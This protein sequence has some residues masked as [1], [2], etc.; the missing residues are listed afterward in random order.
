MIPIAIIIVLS[1]LVVSA[2]ASYAVYTKNK[3][4]IC[5]KYAK[6]SGSTFTCPNGFTKTSTGC[7]CPNGYVTMSGDTPVCNTCPSNAKC[8]DT[9][10]TCGSGFIKGETSCVCPVNNYIKG[11]GST[12]KCDPCP[13]NALCHGTNSFDC[14]NNFIKSE[15]GCECQGGYITGSGNRVTCNECPDNSTCSNSGFIC[16]NGFTSNGSACICPPSKYTTAN[17]L[18]TNCPTNAI[19]N[20]GTGYTCPPG[21]IDLGNGLGCSCGPNKTIMGSGPTL[22]CLTCMDTSAVTCKADG[23]FTC[24]SPY[25]LTNRECLCYSG[26]GYIDSNGTCS[27]CPN[28]AICNGTGYNC[29][30]YGFTDVNGT[31]MCPSGY[32]SF[33]GNNYFCRTPCPTNANCASTYGQYGPRGYACNNNYTLMSDGSCLC[34][35]GTGYIN[36]SGA[37]VPCPP[38]AKC[39]GVNSDC[40]YY[41]FTKQNGACVCN[42]DYISFDGT[43]YHCNGPCPEHASC[44]NTY[45]DNPTGYTC[46][47]GFTNI[48]NDCICNGYITPLLDMPSVGS[49]IAGVIGSTCDT[50]PPRAD[51]T[52]N[53]LKC[54]NGFVRGTTNVRDPTTG[55]M[56]STYSC[57][58]TGYITGTGSNQKCNPCPKYGICGKNS[59]TFT[60]TGNLTRV[61]NSSGVGYCACPSNQFIF[62]DINGPGCMDCPKYGICNGTDKYQCPD[63]FS[64]TDM[65]CLCPSTSYVT[66]PGGPCVTCPPH[67]SCGGTVGFNCPKPLLVSD[68]GRSCK[69]PDGSNI[70]GDV[71]SLSCTLS[72]NSVDLPVTV[73]GSITQPTLA[74]GVVNPLCEVS[75]PDTGSEIKFIWI[76][77]STPDFTNVIYRFTKTFTIDRVKP[78]EIGFRIV[79]VGVVWFN[80]QKLGTCNP[81]GC[82]TLEGTFM[83]NTVVGTNV[84][85]VDAI[86]LDFIPSAPMLCG[87]V[88]TIAVPS[89][90]TTPAV[91]S[92]LLITT[93][94][95]WTSIPLSHVYGAGPT[96]ASKSFTG[97]D[98][99]IMGYKCD[100]DLAW[101]PGYYACTKCG[102]GAKV[103]TVAIG[104]Y[105]GTYN[106]LDPTDERSRCECIDNTWLLTGDGST[107]KKCPSNSNTLGTGIPITNNGTTGSSQCKC[108]DFSLRWNGSACVPC[109]SNTVTNGTGASVQIPTEPGAVGICACPDVSFTW[110]GSACVKCPPNSSVVG[111]GGSVGNG[112]ICIGTDMYWNGSSCVSCPGGD[113]YWNGSSCMQCPGNS[114]TNGIGFPTN[115]PVCK[116]K[117]L[118]HYWKPNLNL[119]DTCPLGSMPIG[120]IGS[121]P[122]QNIVPGG[123]DGVNV[124]GW[125]PP[126]VCACPNGPWPCP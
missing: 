12:A 57:D 53:L 104:E 54:T 98:T 85:Y 124:L 14:P 9:D 29:S 75:C 66:E 51:C 90:P 121:K 18:C 108:N 37:C 71:V 123:P 78:I 42:K 38:Y 50:C 87:F 73:L 19:C 83:V 80:D 69:C 55:L 67:A 17:G 113:M 107:C 13:S 39:D 74:G 86:H 95:S 81:D 45:S 48:S 36:G 34:Y 84:L 115:I 76:N 103:A 117:T 5:P 118:K 21:F 44:Y 33:D 88:S 56:S 110:N 41:G 25:T 119:C 16:T 91:A 93:D 120:N 30:A 106:P 24:K 47:T 31:C 3:S 10:F 7:E 101:D 15:L 26:T 11:S 62:N 94:S 89:T 125:A 92:T 1:L 77:S 8:S 20:G 2:G 116:C 65:Q 40:G 35:G 59:N 4:I 23:T 6:C 122:I 64:T 27:K 109:P 82:D 96:S 114:S 102:D 49:N 43:N 46:D 28:Y 97:V 105:V 99:G 63:G 70:S 68:D 32:I 22:K 61:I 112:C 111:K 58:C 100:T 52:G 126:D 79:G 72:P 60:C